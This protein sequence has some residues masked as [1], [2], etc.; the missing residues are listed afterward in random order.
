MPISALDSDFAFK[1]GLPQPVAEPPG[2]TTDPLAALVGTWRGSG[3]NAIW[4]PHFPESES[5]H[6]LML[7]VTEEILSFSRIAGPI[8]NRGLLQSDISMTGLTYMDQISD[9]MGNG[10]H[11][12]PG[13]WAAVPATSSPEVPQSVVRMA[14]IPHGTTILAQGT[15]SDATPGA[16]TIPPASLAP[17][18][19]GGGSAGAFSELTV[20]GDPPFRT[21]PLPAEVTQELLDD[22]NS[23]LRTTLSGEEV[24]STVAL[25]VATNGQPL[26]GGGQSNTAF[27][28]GMNPDDE[29]GNASAN[30]VSATFWIESVAAQGDR[31]AF[32]QLQYTQTVML[33]FA[34]LRWPHVTVATLRQTTTGPFPAFPAP[35]RVDED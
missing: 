15:A 7:N 23:L 29:A 27:L 22:P 1:T 31:P 33:D 35:P 26:P 6:F 20:A 2:P 10:L 16:P 18:E 21:N 34:T 5:D 30:L 19:P 4:R 24:T 25:S 8:P 32:M 14:S 9:N 12:E 3:F 17:I 13:I 11:I 28:A